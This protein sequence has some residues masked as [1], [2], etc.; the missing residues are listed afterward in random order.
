M[1]R[2][3]VPDDRAVSPVVEKTLA[4]GLVTL[5]VSLVSV[6]VY[7][8]VVPDARTTAGHELADRTLAK[9]TERVQQ[10][11]PPNAT[12]VTVRLRVS[13]PATIRGAAYD[14]RTDGRAL[15]FDHP[16]DELDR[17][18]LLALPSS[19]VRVEGRW[20]SGGETFVHVTS[21]GSGLVVR[22]ETGGGS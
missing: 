12:G 22:L 9:A 5:Y 4:I 2:P 18:A 14:V 11:V 3:P 21:T 19:V 6:T 13:L 20:Q 15:V 1:W 16:N 10:A 17:R 8:G 7:G